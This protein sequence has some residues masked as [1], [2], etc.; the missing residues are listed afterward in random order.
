[1][2]ENQDLRQQVETSHEETEKLSK[3]TQAIIDRAKEIL[4]GIK[5][6]SPEHYEE[7]IKKY[8]EIRKKTIEYARTQNK[9]SR[10][11]KRE[12][13]RD[14]NSM[15]SIDNNSFWENLARPIH[16]INKLNDK[17][18]ILE[19]LIQNKD[20]I[21]EPFLRK[22]IE[23]EISRLKSG[24]EKTL[25][26]TYLDT[27][28]KNLDNNLDISKK[29]HNAAQD[30]II[31]KILRSTKWYNN[32]YIQGY[33]SQVSNYLIKIEDFEQDIHSGRTEITWNKDNPNEI[34]SKALASYISYLSAWWANNIEDF[35]QK[36]WPNQLFN[37]WKIWKEKKSEKNYWIAKTT[38]ENS[39][40]KNIVHIIT[41]FS[42]G[43][44]EDFI[45]GLQE[46]KNDPEA[47]KA[48]LQYYESNIAEIQQKFHK[49]F[50]DAFKK[51][52]PEMSDEEINANIDELM[53]NID[54][55]LWL[56]EDG[57][58]KVDSLILAFHQFNKKHKLGFEW[59][60]FVSQA[61]TAIDLG[62]NKREKDIIQWQLEEIT[63]TPQR[64]EEIAKKRKELYD[65]H[66]LLEEAKIVV[67]SLQSKDPETNKENIKKVIAGGYE[68][69]YKKL[70]EENEDLRKIEAQIQVIQ[71][72]RENNRE[73]KMENNT[74]IPDWEPR[75]EAQTKYQVNDNWGNYTISKP[76]EESINITSEEYRIINNPKNTEALESIVQFK[77]DMDEMWLGEIFKLRKYIFKSISIIGFDAWDSDYLNE[78]EVKLF[79]STFL[80]SLRPEINESQI[81][82]QNAR[83]DEFKN[84]TI[85]LNKQNSLTGQDE[86]DL[87]GN[88]YLE[89]IFKE[90]YYKDDDMLFDQWKFQK[91]IK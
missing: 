85:T 30:K 61:E 36:F 28:V 33:N 8:E 59:R 40:L 71:Q 64:K 65:Q 51:K 82:S 57:D 81:P 55:V 9:I 73:N 84:Q 23:K 43:K 45:W 89:H 83:Y 17:G 78:N 26:S 60:D 68:Q 5:T 11:E 1:M 6:E 75:K 41:M 46:I 20:R 86:V 14:I 48:S 77:Q 66:T 34:N 3:S 56:M 35:I 10:Q 32:E 63:A 53:W 37:L 88:S 16:V 44:T 4:L 18:D 74:V 67:Q 87:N 69:Y 47:L 52:S 54:N 80:K 15:G 29:I 13:S 7:A 62:Q 22:D 19:A 58:V 25:W 49:D 24:G 91:A 31:A 39:G 72:K 27:I 90:K 76:G 42:E 38:L 21:T 50:Y 79:L 70:L 12:L 2:P